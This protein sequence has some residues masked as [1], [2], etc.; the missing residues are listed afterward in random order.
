RDN[1]REGFKTQSLIEEID[2]YQ[3]DTSKSLLQLELRSQ[4]ETAIKNLPEQMQKVFRL[5]RVDNVRN[6]EI[7]EK[8]DIAIKTVETHLS[9]ATKIL[10][11][12]LK[13][14]SMIFLIFLHW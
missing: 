5:S 12:E 9:R 8:L 1:Y 7:A 4:L 2:F 13:D 6:I 14:Y 11:K 10:R 3:N